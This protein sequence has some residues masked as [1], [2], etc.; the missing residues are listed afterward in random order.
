MNRA[1]SGLA[2]FFRTHPEA[3]IAVGYM[4]FYL[5]A[6]F[7]LERVVEPRFII[8]SRL[9]DLIPFCEWGIIPY[10]SWYL[11]LVG[12]PVF[13]LLK[14]KNDYLRLCFIMYVGMTICLA[15]YVVLPTGLDL[16][17]PIPRDNLLCKAVELI[18]A[19]DT[20][21]NVCPSIH[22][23]STVAVGIVTVRSRLFRRHRWVKVLMVAECLAMCWA[24]LVLQQHS[25]WDVVAGAA[26]SFALM[27][28]AWKL[29][30]QAEKAPA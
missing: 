18:R 19:A 5:A 3:W 25:V 16:R 26:L 12:G 23:S 8:H 11:L 7:L 10:C 14:D 15:L 4:A 27:P 13:F 30:P 9:D 1:K 2:A 6:F 28:L 29:W 24:T 21:T 22:I 17:E 20:P